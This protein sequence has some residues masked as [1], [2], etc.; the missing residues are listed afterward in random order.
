REGA[1]IRDFVLKFPQTVAPIVAVGFW[2]TELIEAHK[3]A[4]TSGYI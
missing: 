2:G 3:V 1:S 4:M